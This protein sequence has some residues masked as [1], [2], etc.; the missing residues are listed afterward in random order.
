MD[1]C[2]LNIEFL[3]YHLK[4]YSNES[5]NLLKELI[6]QK[7][8]IFYL[9]QWSFVQQVI[10]KHVLFKNKIFRISESKDISDEGRKILNNE[11]EKCS[12]LLL[13]YMQAKHGS[14]SGAVRYSQILT[15][16]EAMIYFGQ[17]G[18]EFYAYFGIL[19]QHSP[20]KTPH[21]LDQIFV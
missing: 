5:L 6:L 17:K 11:F 19:F 16:M 13:K 3:N 7:M 2:Q 12:N 21:L 20:I 4:V 10:F 8:N 18:R 9:K 14:T 1:K 15:I